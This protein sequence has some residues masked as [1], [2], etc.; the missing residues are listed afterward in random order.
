MISGERIE[1]VPSTISDKK[2]VYRW[3]CESETTKN[4][5]GPPNFEDH[6]IPTWE[7]YC[8]DFDDYY[9]DG[10]KPENGRVYILKHEEEE[11]GAICYASF[12]L[13][14]RSAELDIWM[15]SEKNCGRGLGTEA[16]KLLCDHLENNGIE[17]LIIRP[18]ER[19]VRAVKAYEKA[20][21]IK[22]PNR[23]KSAVIEQCLREEFLE[24]YGAG[25]YGNGDDVVLIKE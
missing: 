12:H 17:R 14:N 4:H 23:E 13:N 25:D 9:F 21:F 16:I 19:N 5:M 2:K 24:L 8:Q 11:I 10:T 20:G 1:I 18:S 3:L 22:V 7:D 6:P 15:G